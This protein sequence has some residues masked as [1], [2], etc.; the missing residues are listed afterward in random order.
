[1]ELNEIKR[2]IPT[3]SGGKQ[4]EVPGVGSG[5]RRK[6]VAR[7]KQAEKDIEKIKDV[8]EGSQSVSRVISLSI[9]KGDEKARK[10]MAGVNGALDALDDALAQLRR[11]VRDFK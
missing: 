9:D 10:A 4:G 1:M 2:L 8:L 5:L 7:V 11:V 3:L 6:A